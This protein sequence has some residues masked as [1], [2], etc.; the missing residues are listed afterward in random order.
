MIQETPGSVMAKKYQ[1]HTKECIDFIDNSLT[2]TVY[3]IE[4]ICKKEAVQE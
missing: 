1:A 4:C 3:H 2:A